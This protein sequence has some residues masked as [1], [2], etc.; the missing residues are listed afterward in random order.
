MTERNLFILHV[1]QLVLGLGAAQPL[2]WLLSLRCW[3]LFLVVSA[4]CHLYKVRHQVSQI[5]YY[6]QHHP[7]M[8]SDSAPSPIAQPPSADG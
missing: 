4:L 3:R 1:L 7:G 8:Q 6:L 5:M 2:F